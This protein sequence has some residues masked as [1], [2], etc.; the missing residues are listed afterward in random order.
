[1]AFALPRR[2]FDFGDASPAVELFDR[3]ALGFDAPDSWTGGI[4]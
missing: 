1:M 4:D 2:D 3:R